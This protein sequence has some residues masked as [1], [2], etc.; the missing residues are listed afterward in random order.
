MEKVNQ[1][2][3]DPSLFVRITNVLERLE[4]LS[5]NLNLWKAQNMYFS[6]REQLTAEMDEKAKKGGGSAKEWLDAF[7]GLGEKLRIK[8]N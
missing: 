3:M 8:V 6:L 1:D 7:N 4:S 2:P 5:F